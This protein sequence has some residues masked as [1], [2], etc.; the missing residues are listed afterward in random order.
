MSRTRFSHLP[1]RHGQCHNY[2]SDMIRSCYR[3][4]CPGHIF[5]KGRPNP[6]Q[7]YMIL[8]HSMMVCHA[9]HL[10]T[11]SQSQGYKFGEKSTFSECGHVAYQIK[12]KENMTTKGQGHKIGKKY[13]FSECGHVAY[14]IIKKR[15]KCTTTYKQIF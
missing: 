13:T 2:Y 8:T 7:L 1:P 10:A 12:R 9:H 14:Q 5:Y 6:L 4:S 15:M 11:Y 3:I